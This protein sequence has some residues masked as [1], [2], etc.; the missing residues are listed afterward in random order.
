M[1]VNNVGRFDHGVTEGNDQD[2]YEISQFL[3]ETAIF[4]CV[5]KITL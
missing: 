3:M 4:L 1:L 5:L 2:S